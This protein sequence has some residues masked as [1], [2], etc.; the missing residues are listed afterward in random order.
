VPVELEE[1]YKLIMK[2]TPI[3]IKSSIN[4]AFERSIEY[5]RGQNFFVGKNCLKSLILFQQYFIQGK[6]YETT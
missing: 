5:V 1:D 6:D 3:I 4:T 2:K